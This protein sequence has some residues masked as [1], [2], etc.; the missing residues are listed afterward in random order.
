MDLSLFRL[1]H[2]KGRQCRVST[3][4]EVKKLPVPVRRGKC[5]ELVARTRGDINLRG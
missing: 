4:S 3:P 1:G 2:G 5:T